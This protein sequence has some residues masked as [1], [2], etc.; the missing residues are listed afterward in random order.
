[1]STVVA[2]ILAGAVGAPA[3]F[4]VDDVIARS[5]GRS[6]PIGTLVI[7]VTG[8]LLLGLLGGLVLHRAFSP[9]IYRVLGTGFCGSFTTFST[10]TFETARL[11]QDGRR[12]QAAVYWLCTAGLGVGAAALGLAAA[13]AS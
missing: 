6:W 13:I 4:L 2:V 12:W 8:S 11:V 7:N 10:F 9:E 1:M 5:A 3:R